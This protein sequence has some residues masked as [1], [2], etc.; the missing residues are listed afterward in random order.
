MC[1]DN[2]L[3]DSTQKR[4][5]FLQSYR[6]KSICVSFEEVAQYN[7][8]KNREI[9]KNSLVYI[10]HD[11]I[12]A[13]GHDGTGKQVVAGCTQAIQELS[14]LVSKI[15]SSYNVTEVY[16]TADTPTMALSLMIWKWQRKTN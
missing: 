14:I 12:D 10:F 7:T 4:S 16:V 5:E 2:K 13:S 1:V 6:D 8:E 9:F 11:S 15:L 3:L